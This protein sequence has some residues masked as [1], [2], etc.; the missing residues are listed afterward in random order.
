MRIVISGGSGF[1]GRHVAKGFIANNH[2]VIFL[3]RKNTNRAHLQ[4][5]G[6]SIRLYVHDN[7]ASN[8]VRLFTNEKPDLICHLAAKAQVGYAI[9]E[10][11]QMLDSNFRLGLQIIDAM[12]ETGVR[13]FINT[14][15]PWQYSN[16]KKG[17]CSCLYA[18]LKEAF[19]GV[20]DL[21]LIHI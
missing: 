9:N 8:L 21:S 16:G 20:L 2:D 5:F 11:D 3:I 17:Q 10:L 1:I 18:A 14:A 4:S 12:R 19:D 13:F 7:S 15:T 6:D